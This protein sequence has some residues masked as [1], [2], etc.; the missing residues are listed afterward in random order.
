MDFDIVIENGKVIDGAGNPWYRADIGI[1]GGKIDKIGRIG[2]TGAAVRI[3]AEDMIVCPGF[4]DV[5]SH[6]DVA[7]LFDNSL[8][9]TVRQ[10]ITT[11]VLGNCGENLAP[12]A[13]ESIG[14]ILKMIAVYSPPGVTIDSLPWTTFAQYL[15]HMESKGCVANS[16]HMVG[17]GPVRIARGP[18]FED[19]PP[20]PGELERMRGLV[21]EA[22]EAGAFGLSTGLVYT[23]QAYAKTG[24]I[25]EMAKVAARYGGLYFSHIRGEGATVVDAVKEAIE[26][27]QASGCAGGHIAHH[28][29][30]G[31]SFWGTSK[32]TL[33]LLE[34]ANNRGI[35]M[36]CDQ[37]PYNRGM[38]SLSALLPPW[39]HEGGA[40][41]LLERLS[42]E[43]Q[44][45]R[46][47]RD[48]AGDL[49]GGG[50]WLQESGFDNIYIAYV[51]TN[52]WKDFE[53]ASLA[54]ISRRT[55]RTN[56]F[57]T[58]FDILLEE[59]GEAAVTIESMG[60]EDIR[61][62]MTSRYTMFGTDAW[63]VAPDGVM[64]FGKPHPRYYGT[65]PRILGRYVREERVLTL[66]DA[67]R[68]MTS[69][70]AQRLGLQNR[71]LLREGMWADIVIFD[72]AEIIDR[73]TY[74]KPHQFP[75]G[76]LHVL[77][78]GE[79]VVSNG[80]QTDKLPGKLLR[81]RA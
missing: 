78:N 60:E 59:K 49:N 54:E 62:I 13:A 75:A 7:L 25:I 80:K 48:L 64:G 10:G 44:R 38:T 77:V 4:I 42:D 66:E 74:Q 72:P 18:G 21:A 37:Y 55:G 32:R 5:H 9:S 56:G 57:D 53:G 65:F 2:K 26:I 41:K 30:A 28:K 81:R 22:M 27:V 47:K 24:E 63:G 50:N 12:V 11:S 67:I 45:T 69:F 15:E 16:A 20:D 34:E 33:A 39:A 70:P 52:K 73:A 46:I 31:R 76:I 23:P 51:K 58:L 43:T 19:R 36:T 40:E 79:P 8:Q 1:R 6:S 35:N 14:E 68:R 3:P 71:G 29:I 61:R 17:F